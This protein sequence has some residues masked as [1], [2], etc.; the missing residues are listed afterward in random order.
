MEEEHEVM[1]RAKVR[2]AELAS[3]RSR[4]SW[5][6]ELDECPTWASDAW[7]PL[8]SLEM[9][10]NVRSPSD[11]A[12]VADAGNG[13]A[14]GPAVSSGSRDGVLVTAGGDGGVNG[15]ASCDDP[16]RNHKCWP[17]VDR[18]SWPPSAVVFIMLVSCILSHLIQ[19][20]NF[21]EQAAGELFIFLLFLV[22]ASLVVLTIDS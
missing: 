19:S 5:A 12:T 16:S 15:R 18:P 7:A 9:S 22:H 13:G 20:K 2:I 21:F 11:A 6:R 14:R 8:P 10:T 1:A 17:R 4:T 3:D